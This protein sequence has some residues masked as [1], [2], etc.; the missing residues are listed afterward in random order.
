MA[1]K[2]GTGSSVPELLTGTT[3]AVRGLLLISEKEAKA[4]LAKNP[5]TGQ[6][7]S[8]HLYSVDYTNPS[9]QGAIG[10]FLRAVAQSSSDF[11]TTPSLVAVSTT[12]NKL[13]SVK[14]VE[15]IENRIKN[16]TKLSFEEYILVATTDPTL[17]SKFSAADISKNSAAWNKFSATA[18]KIY[19]SSSD[20]TKSAY[21]I[22]IKRLTGTTASGAS[23]RLMTDFVSYDPITTPPINAYQEF[24]DHLKS[25][26]EIYG[27]EGVPN[28]TA[29]FLLGFQL[30]QA[31]TN[32]TILY[33]K[34]YKRNFY[35]TGTDI[36]LAKWLED[37]PDE[38]MTIDMLTEEF[39][40]MVD[41]PYSNLLLA[42]T[43]GSLA[44]K[45]DIAHWKNAESTIK[46]LGLRK[47]LEE[48]LIKAKNTLSDI[49]T[50]LRSDSRNEDL[51]LKKDIVTSIVTDLEKNLKLITEE[52]AAAR[53][54]TGTLAGLFDANTSSADLK[55][56]FIPSNS[57]A[58]EVSDDGKYIQINV[59]NKTTTDI[60]FKTGTITIDSQLAAASILTAQDSAVYSLMNSLF[61]RYWA[62][63]KEKVINNTIGKILSE[64]GSFSPITMIIG[65]NLQKIFGGSLPGLEKELKTNK[66][67]R[68]KQT[69][70]RMNIGRV[71]KA[72]SGVINSAKKVKS[73]PKGRLTSKIKNIKPRTSTIL[74]GVRVRGAKLGY[75]SIRNKDFKSLDVLSQIN[76]VL[77]QEVMKEMKYPALVSRTGRFAGSVVALS[78]HSGIVEYDYM[79][80]PYAVFEQGALGRAPWNS[81]PQR[82]PR[83]IINNA[84]SNIGSKLGIK[85]E[86]FKR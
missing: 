49:D 84:I 47:T 11:R 68:V 8:V 46:N 80:T 13:L 65:M 6:E 62:G 28:T 5:L 82:D 2:P 79:T 69:S 54:I 81:I 10:A 75:T 35:V 51:F 67:A 73:I 15:E 37:N 23:V 66:P 9:D 56:I 16:T 48:S 53:G 3:G 40:G 12:S 17:Q 27:R 38:P 64:A 72:K 85:L 4:R 58:F 57:R 78:E 22:E 31:S 18:T 59:V 86:G 25:W 20:S 32:N 71:A 77:K 29:Y 43:V 74:P 83:T 45:K 36:V 39:S 70:G 41:G 52:I 61:N 21:D 55:N 1:S 19:G 44:D 7:R 14:E 30:V 63:P 34:R 24:T 50:Q 33:L 76:Q 42:P 26:L 60:D